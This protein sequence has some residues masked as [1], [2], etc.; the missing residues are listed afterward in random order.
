MT[1]RINRPSYDT[2]RNDKRKADR[3]HLDFETWRDHLAAP[4][5]RFAPDR[6]APS[7]TVRIDAM[8]RR[9]DS[10]EPERRAA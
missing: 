8:S 1:D 2:S 10:A 4:G 5:S 9:V 3:F 6:A 7:R